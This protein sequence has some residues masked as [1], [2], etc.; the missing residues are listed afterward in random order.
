MPVTKR[1]TNL[2]ISDC[3]LP[4]SRIRFPEAFPA[5]IVMRSF[6]LLEKVIEVAVYVLPQS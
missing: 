2:S 5:N 3:T 4:F 1:I 6:H